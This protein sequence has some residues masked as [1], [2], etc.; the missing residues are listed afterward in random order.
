MMISSSESSASDDSTLATTF[1]FGA[2]LALGL[3]TSSSESS[4]ALALDLGAA[5]ALGLIGSSSESDM[6][7]AFAFE[8][9]ALAGAALVGAGM[10]YT[11]HQPHIS[12]KL[13]NSLS[14]SSES[15][16][17]IGS[18]FAFGLA[19]AGAAFLAGGLTSSPSDT[20]ALIVS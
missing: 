19:F 10:L 15:S 14:S 5:F 11:I 1:F 20:L 7:F 8:V 2:G 18:T 4:T 13:S 9:V 12:E 17:I 6:A 16:R 3:T